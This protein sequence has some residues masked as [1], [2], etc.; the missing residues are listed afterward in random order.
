MYWVL[1]ILKHGA[2]GIWDEVLAVGL[3]V[4]FTAA[5][6]ITWLY[7]RKFEP[8]LEGEESEEEKWQ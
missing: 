6:I 2:F 4:L 7:S 8:E 3:A 1:S 5:F